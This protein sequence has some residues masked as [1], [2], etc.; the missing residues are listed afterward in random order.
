MSG[1][2]NLG[3]TCIR[4]LI[5]ATM[6]QRMSI[7]RIVRYGCFGLP[8]NQMGDAEFDEK[9]DFD[10][11]QAEPARL[12][13]ATGRELRLSRRADAL[14]DAVTRSQWALLIA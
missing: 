11:G 13:R 3:G 1:L 12:K 10:L 6:T 2:A 9:S 5:L 7:G 8:A 4:R 14:G